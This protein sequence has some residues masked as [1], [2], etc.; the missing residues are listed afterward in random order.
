MP[1][2]EELNVVLES[3]STADPDWNLREQLRKKVDEEVATASCSKDISEMPS[4]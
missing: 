4:L 1:S 2:P 3:Q